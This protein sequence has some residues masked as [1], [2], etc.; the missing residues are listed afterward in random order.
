MASRI[1]SRVSRRRL[2]A[3]ADS[4]FPSY[5]P[6][7][8]LRAFGGVR[9]FATSPE[10][11]D[12]VVIGGGPGGYVAA[13]KAAQLGMKVTCVEKRGALGGTCLNVG[14]IPSKALLESSHM[15]HEAKH[16]FAAH[17][18]KVAGLE[19]DL[20]AMMAQK[21]GAVAGLTKGI[22]GLFK[23]NKVTYVKGHGKIVGP[24]EVAVSLLDSPGETK[25]IGAKNIIIATGSDVRP[26]P[27]LQ[28][29]E[30]KVVSS[31]GALSLDA[32]P[33]KLVVVGGGVIGL[34]L[35]SVWGRLGAQ[36]TVVEFMDGIGGYMD[37]EIRRT[38]QRTLQ[39]QGFKF[40]LSTKVVSADAS[41]NG[42][43]LEVE[44]A[45]GGEKT[46]L[47]ADV[48]LVATGRV[49]YTDGLGLEEVGVQKDKAGRIVVDDKF[50]SSVPSV[51]AIG[52]AIPG[53]MLAHKAEEDGIACVENLAGKHGHVNYATVPG[54]IYTH[55]EVA[56]VGKT[57]EEVKESG[58][59]Y[60]VG[61]FPFMANSRART[62]GDSEGMVK[63]IAEKATDKVVGVHIVG[64]SAGE[65]IMECVLAMEYGASSEDIA[66]TCHGHPTLSEAVKE[67]A[68]A[69]HGKPIHM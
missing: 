32:V 28:I 17:G 44:P 8:A 31:T 60:R 48:V 53:P 39:K 21:T 29:D 7:G 50:R 27:G 14:C 63:I 56:M 23:K 4:A 57:E 64:P 9:W 43:V 22:E 12:I 18:V 30:K 6:T 1:L 41:G 37:N 16:S 26:L 62:I 61:K 2:S 45:K 40:M 3:V 67:A 54:I 36:V 25:S 24:N 15:Y 11:N 46:K 58:V 65:L 55:P 69:T 38:F 49:P 20:P 35:G 13:I 47:E 19:V 68:L 34:E 42:V 66:R 52:D 5:A 10:E 51:F 59:E 33:K